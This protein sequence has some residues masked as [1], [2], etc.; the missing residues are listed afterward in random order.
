MTVFELRVAVTT[1]IF[2]QLVAFYRDGLGLNPGEL[3]TE[4]G[5][6]QIFS[7]GRATLEVF[8]PAH[9][10]AVD[11]LEVG[12][13]VSGQFRFAFEVPD[14][15]AAL[16]RAL[17]YGATLVHEPVLTPWNDLNAR[18]TSPDGLQITLFQ[19]MPKG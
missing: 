7:A 12:E 5:R 8:D 18:V 9:A 16:K 2:D 6:G 1:E 17:E 4:H 13:R 3:W 15:H 11:Q 10:A 14:V 19:V